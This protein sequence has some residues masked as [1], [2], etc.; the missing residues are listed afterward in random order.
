[1]AV[2]GPAASGAWV[3]A[4]TAPAAVPSAQTNHEHP[5]WGPGGVLTRHSWP[6]LWQAWLCL[7]SPSL[8][9][10][11][12]TAHTTGARTGRRPRLLLHHHP[13]AQTP[14]LQPTLPPCCPG[15]W[16]WAPGS[17]ELDRQ[18]TRQSGPWPHCSHPIHAPRTPSCHGQFLAVLPGRWVGASGGCP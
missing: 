17:P 18:R 1:M 13:S 2:H 14:P 5:G 11:A 16:P 3:Q 15:E 4:P 7:G 12:L 8:P 10:W 9:A 6:N